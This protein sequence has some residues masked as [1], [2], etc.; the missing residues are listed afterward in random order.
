MEFPHILHLTFPRGTS[1]VTMVL[2]ETDI[3]TMYSLNYRP[4]SDFISFYMHSFKILCVCIHRSF[5]F[6]FLIIFNLYCLFSKI[7]KLKVKILVYG[8]VKFAYMCRFV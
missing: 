8:I 1:F 4:Y 2:C 6:Y 3:A 7:F 5:I